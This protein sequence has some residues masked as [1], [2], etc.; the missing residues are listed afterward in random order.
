MKFK[1]RKSKTDGQWKFK[2][3]ASNGETIMTSEA[4]HNK[5]DALQTIH[6]IIRGVGSASIEIEGED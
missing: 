2:L 3:V 6:S 5:Q 1:V 4:Y